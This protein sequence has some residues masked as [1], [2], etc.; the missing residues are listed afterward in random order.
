[1]TT[2]KI[3]KAPVGAFFFRV[4]ASTG[5]R[6]VGRHRYQ[7]CF[8][9]FD[10]EKIRETGKVKQGSARIIYFDDLQKK[11]VQIHRD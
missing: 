8:A 3:K 2:D 10:G 5:R 1:M 11:T 4:D 9:L 6:S 7:D